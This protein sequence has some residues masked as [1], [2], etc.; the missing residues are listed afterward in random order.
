MAGFM[1]SQLSGSYDPSDVIFL[2]KEVN[3][4]P[5]GIVDKEALIQSGMNHYSE[6]ISR[7]RRPD[8]RY[9]EIYE[10]A[11]ARSGHRIAREIVSLARLIAARITKGD[12]NA[13]ITLCSLVRAG[14]PYGILLRRELAALGVD[15]VHYGISII[16][17]RGLDHNAMDYIMSTR[18]ANGIVFVD[19]W[20]GKGAISTEL[21]SSWH[22]ISGLKPE[23]AVLADPSGHAGMS[24]SHEDWLIPS[25]LLG[26]NVSGLISRSILNNTV[27][28]PEDF[29]GTIR[30]G[31]LESLDVSRSFVDRITRLA[32]HL[33]T[34]PDI[35]PAEYGKQAKAHTNDLRTVATACINRIAE[36]HGIDNLNLIKPGI[37]EATRVVLRRRPR[38]V[39]LQNAEDPDL[40][41]LV[42]LCQ[43]DR[44]EMEICAETTGPWRAI[45]LI[46]QVS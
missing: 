5:T 6:M 40:A 42:H 20:T 7:E 34:N 36:L 45:T 16:R 4:A 46:R 13:Q 32:R 26:A 3:L 28:D 22:E 14:I 37:A 11:L 21:N 24:G 29:H 39:F 30:V 19:G 12:L 33:R 9:M 1:P 25:G 15:S 18:P 2:L 38:K 27:L 8:K 43:T 31:Y 10:A 17:D 35:V 23:L 41:A 44:I